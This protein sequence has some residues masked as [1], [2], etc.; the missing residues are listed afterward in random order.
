[1][2]G[3]GRLTVVSD[4]LVETEAGKGGLWEQ[5]VEIG[6]GEVDVGAE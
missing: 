6:D 3:I 2:T 5:G 1:M 4:T